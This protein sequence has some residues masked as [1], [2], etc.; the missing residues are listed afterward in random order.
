MSSNQRAYIA[1][2]YEFLRDLTH[3]KRTTYP[4]G[5]RWG[6]IVTYLT[7]KEGGVD[8]LRLLYTNVREDPEMNI[9]TIADFKEFIVVCCDLLN[10]HYE[11]ELL[12]WIT[13]DMDTATG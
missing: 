3:R 13:E 7:S 12:Q 5:R 9:T 6:T 10:S 4:N 11:K 1:K 8:G 2:R